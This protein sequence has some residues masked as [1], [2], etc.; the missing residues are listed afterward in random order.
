MG[1]VTERR[2]MPETL[3]VLFVC[4]HGSAK[5]V[6]AARH[7]ERLARARGF[8]VECSSAGLD[9]DETIPVH[10]IDGLRADGFDRVGE[11][12]ERVTGEMLSGADIVVSFGC[13]LSSFGPPPSTLVRWEDVP[14]VSDGFAVAR[15]FITRRLNGLF[16]I[17]EID[18]ARYHI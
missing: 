7:F 2:P 14:A 3:R 11:R 16:E 9:P 18:P 12:P 4:L 10:V 8:D 5:S 13:D 1:R 15:E 6:I 17:A